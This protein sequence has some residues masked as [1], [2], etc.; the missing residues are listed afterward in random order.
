MLCV[1]AL[2]LIGHTSAFAQPSILTVSGQASH[3]GSLT[4]NGSGFGAKSPAAPLVW[5]DASGTRML[6]KWTHAD[7]HSAADSVYNIQYRS[8]PYRNVLPPHNRVGRMIVGGHTQ[9]GYSPWNASGGPNV[10]MCKNTGGTENYFISFYYRLD[11]LWPPNNGEAVANPNH[12]L[13][14]FDPS[15]N[16]SL[17]TVQ[18]L[19]YRNLPENSAAQYH[20]DYMACEAYP[21]PRPTVKEPWNWVKIE[22][23]GVDIHNRNNR[24]TITV[25]TD[26][27]SGYPRQEN[28]NVYRGTTNPIGSI[29]IGYY[30]TRNN[31][32]SPVLGSN[33]A[34]RYF[35]DVYVDNTSARVVLAN[36]QNYD[37]ATIVE[38]QIPS[39]WGTGSITC[40]VNLGRLPDYG[41]AYLFV[42]D[43]NNNRNATGYPIEL[44]GGSPISQ[45][46]VPPTG[47]KVIAQ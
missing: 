41:T 35:A 9:S 21:E 36:N 24:A 27:V 33:D 44:A 34:Y 25:S 28:C 18:Y 8:A 47:L 46:P 20:F 38:P 4:I 32:A 3:K 26:N 43:S 22:S 37:A 2:C 17:S 5:D 13:A 29:G 10:M 30:W 15:G 12:K 40:T 45:A 23:A 14:F 7:P 19:E 11:P 1:I 31:T 16:C 6:D 42:F 39:A